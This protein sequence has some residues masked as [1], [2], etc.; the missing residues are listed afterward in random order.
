MRWLVDLFKEI[1]LSVVLREQLRAARAELETLKARLA[2]RERERDALARELEEA[3]NEIERFKGG[4]SG[5]AE[6]DYDPLDR[7]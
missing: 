7:F 5:R 3:R 4:R 2:E 6:G 1:P